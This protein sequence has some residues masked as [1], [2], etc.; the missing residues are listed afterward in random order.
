MEF[1]TGN[2]LDL[3]SRNLQELDPR[4]F[5]PNLRVLNVSKNNLAKIGEE[6]GNMV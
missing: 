5:K 3:K 6:I 1:T 2:E 4:V